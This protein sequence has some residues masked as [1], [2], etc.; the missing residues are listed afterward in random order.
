MDYA[1]AYGELHQNEKRFPGYSLT[2]YVE[3]IKQL[4]A[5]HQ[6]ER[7]LDFGSGKGFQYLVRRHHEAWGGLLPYC[8]DV[9]VRQLAELP[10]GT[11]GGVICTDVLE[12][13]EERDLPAVLDTI[14]SKCE[15]QGFLFLAISCRPTKKKLPDGRDV[16]VTIKPPSWWVGTLKSAW[17]RSTGWPRIVAHFDVAGHFDEPEHPWDS[18]E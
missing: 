10:A 8:Y 6:P 5:E 17:A 18:A 2:D 1:A 4:V 11:F 16:H 14:L 12:H 13:I 7:L 3:P 9:G 15:G